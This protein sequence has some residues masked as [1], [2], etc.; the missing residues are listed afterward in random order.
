MLVVQLHHNLRRVLERVAIHKEVTRKM[1]MT[2]EKAGLLAVK[3][4]GYLW[5]TREGQTSL[6]AKL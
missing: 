5:K 4:V 3:E 2:K 6:V 1:A